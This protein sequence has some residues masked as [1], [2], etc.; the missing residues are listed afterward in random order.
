VGAGRWG[1]RGQALKVR[2]VTVGAR[3]GR[4]G[5]ERWSNA[6]VRAV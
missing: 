4:E 1:L 6:L 2:L 3:G 5:G